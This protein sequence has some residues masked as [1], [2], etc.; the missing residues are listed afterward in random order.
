MPGDWANDV[1]RRRPDGPDA[2]SPAP[3]STLP[4]TLSTSG[5]R[6]ATRQRR[7]YCTEHDKYHRPFLTSTAQ[8]G[9]GPGPAGPPDHGGPAGLFAQVVVQALPL[10]VK[11]VGA[12]LLP[13]CVAW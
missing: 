3:R 5:S 13:L 2:D 1:S 8:A 11:E 9:Q 4:I 10:R 6:A 12:P 7:L